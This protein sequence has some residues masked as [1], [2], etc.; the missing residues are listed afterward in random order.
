MK[1]SVGEVKNGL[2]VNLEDDL[3]TSSLIYDGFSKDTKEEEAKAI[4]DFIYDVLGVIGVSGFEVNCR[5]YSTPSKQHPES[6]KFKVRDFKHS[7][8]IQE[9][10]FKLG[11]GWKFGGE[12]RTQNMQEGFLYANFD[13][14][15]QCGETIEI[16]DDEPSVEYTLELLRG[17]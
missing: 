1:I 16:F 13:K 15:I 12:R 8:A 6:M 9:E 2:V 17:E 5:P 10:L 4:T 14:T 11:Y 3:K 7:E